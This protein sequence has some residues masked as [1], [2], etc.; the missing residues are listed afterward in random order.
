MKISL[1]IKQEKLR[2]L[3]EVLQ[4]GYVVSQQ[5]LGSAQKVEELG[6]IFMFCVRA[7]CFP[8]V[9]GG[10]FGKCPESCVVRMG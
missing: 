4:N 7:L 6:L 3:E 9:T 5:D 2:D 1:K 8:V 10:G